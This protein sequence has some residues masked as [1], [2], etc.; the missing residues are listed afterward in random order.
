MTI[1]TNKIL[2][3]LTLGEI[4]TEHNQHKHKGACHD[5]CQIGIAGAC[6]GRSIGLSILED[7]NLMERINLTRED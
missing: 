6:N 7:L 2:E 1:T 5:I 4:L 3:H